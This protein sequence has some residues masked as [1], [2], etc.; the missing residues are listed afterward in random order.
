[1][2]RGV[3]RAKVERREVR[4]IVDSMVDWVKVV[5]MGWLGVGWRFGCDG[6]RF[7]NV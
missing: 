5:G 4:R 7:G 3:E 2:L 6:W 1:M